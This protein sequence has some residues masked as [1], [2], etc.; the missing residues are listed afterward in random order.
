MKALTPTDG[1]EPSTE[2]LTAVC[3]TSELSWI[4]LLLYTISRKSQ[5]M[6]EKLT[7]KSTG[8]FLYSCIEYQQEEWQ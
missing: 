4:T 5:W 8:V 2:R 1:I 7:R 6:F 3:S